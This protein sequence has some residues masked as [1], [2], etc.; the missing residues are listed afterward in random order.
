MDGKDNQFH[1]N[2]VLRISEE[3]RRLSAPANG[4]FN[5]LDGSINTTMWEQKLGLEIESRDHPTRTLTGAPKKSLCFRYLVELEQMVA[6]QV[7]VRQKQL[8][9]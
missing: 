5:E 1:M 4:L 9:I 6:A 2:I 3:V 7:G 8:T